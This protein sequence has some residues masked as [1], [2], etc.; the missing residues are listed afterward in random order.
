MPEPEVTA[1]PDIEISAEVAA[2]AKE[3]SAPEAAGDDSTPEALEEAVEP[4]PVAP[5]VAAMHEV[6]PEEEPA[7][8]S[9]EDVSLESI[10]EELKRRE[11]RN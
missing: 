9:D 11:G 7:A 4:E 2:E 6:V 1:E 5:E 8:Q 10:V 3:A